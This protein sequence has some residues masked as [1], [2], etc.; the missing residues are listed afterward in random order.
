MRRGSIK[1]ARREIKAHTGLRG[2]AALLVVA[3]HVQFGAGY[4]L[5]FETATSF[6]NR[7]YLMVDLFFILSGFILCYVM[8]AELGI[9]FA[10]ARTFFRDRFARIYPLHVFALMFLTAFTL[11]TSALLALTGHGR[12]ELGS[13]GD[14]LSQL[15]LLNAWRP[16]HKEWN[17]PSWSISAEA[18]AYILFP[19]LVTVWAARPRLT[20]TAVLGGS[21][22]FYIL[23]GRSLDITVGLAP[24]RCLAGFGLGMVLFHHRAM[25]ERVASLNL[26]QL[27]AVAW[28]LAALAISIRDALIV[29]GFAALVFLT[30]TDRGIVARWLSARPLQWLGTLSYSVYLMHVPVNVALWFV[31]TRL[32]PRLHLDAAVSRVIFLCL[33]IGTVLAVASFTYAFIEKPWRERV[34][35]RRTPS[36][37]AAVAAP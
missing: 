16:A 36:P 32:E 1:P 8:N 33:M 22:A 4:K 37:I 5:P 34:R 30:W 24:L 19:L 12:Q 10:Q 18:L 25:V 26:L 6:F 9:T 23:V 17:V 15:L 31:W 21:L 14:W 35:H 2:F 27:A 3:Y 13:F 11:A 20:E 29:P 7:C 28:I